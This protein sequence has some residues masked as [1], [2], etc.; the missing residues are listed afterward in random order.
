MEG[1]REG[2]REGGKDGQG[3]E[4]QFRDRYERTSALCHSDYVY[5]AFGFIQT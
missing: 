3:G 5:V 2:E 1:G 4:K